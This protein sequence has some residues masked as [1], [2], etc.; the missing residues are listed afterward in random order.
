MLVLL[1]GLALA[2]ED[3]LANVMLNDYDEPIVWPSMPVTYHTNTANQS[4][5]R[6]EAVVAAVVSAAGAWMRHEGSDVDLDYVG[7]TEVETAGHD[8]VNVVYFLDDW[9]ADRSLLALTTVWSERDGKAVGFDIRIN[10]RDHEWTLDPEAEPDKNDLQNTLAHE[11]GHALGFGHLEEED[12]ATM[13]PSAPPGETRK[14]DL[15]DGD[16]A[17]AVGVYPGDQVATTELDNRYEPLAAALCG[18]RPGRPLAPAS[19]LALAG[20]ALG[21]ARRRSEAA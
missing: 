2:D 14:R 16:I 5:L 13:Y 8:Q 21:R 12:E 20:L 18:T 11:F 9:T 1:T 6:E 19:L 4:G 17:M 15:S 3:A 7:S 10:T